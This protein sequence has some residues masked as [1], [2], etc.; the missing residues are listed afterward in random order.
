MDELEKLKLE[1]LTVERQNILNNRPYLLFM[2]DFT[3]EG[4][5]LFEI[6]V[7]IDKINK[8]PDWEKFR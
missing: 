1:R 4:N 6:D 5:R 2:S 3:P 8:E 7:E